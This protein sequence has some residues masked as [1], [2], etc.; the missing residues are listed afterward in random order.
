MGAFLLFVHILA[1]GAWLGASVTQGLVTP[2]MQKTGGAPAAAWMRQTSRMSLVLYMPAA[3]VLLITGFWMVIRDNLYEFEQAFVA[4]GIITVIVGAVLGMRV[5]GP[6]G[7]EAA[8]LHD[9]GD[10]AKVAP[11]HKR[12]AI[13]VLVDTV[14]VVFTIWA[15]VKR[16]GL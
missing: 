9:A 10:E 6:G 7:E 11:L 2:A 15:M 5:F 16:L 14:L 12:L 8:D 13:Y 4:I 3:I 1:A